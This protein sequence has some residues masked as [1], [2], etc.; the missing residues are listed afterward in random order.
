[1]LPDQTKIQLYKRKPDTLR[2]YWP[3]SLIC[4]KSLI[5]KI[6]GGKVCLSTSSNPGGPRLLDALEQLAGD[7]HPLDLGG[8]LVD[9]VDLGVAHQLLRRE[10]RVVAVAAKNLK[11]NVEKILKYFYKD[12]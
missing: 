2:K 9:L 12:K 7:H 11:K 8:A 10:L 6:I 5:S 3:C 1:L 4:G